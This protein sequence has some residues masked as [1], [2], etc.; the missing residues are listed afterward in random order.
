MPGLQ[1]AATF[2]AIPWLDG[3]LFAAGILL[4]IELTIEVWPAAFIFM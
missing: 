2:F 4:R 3:I 1:L